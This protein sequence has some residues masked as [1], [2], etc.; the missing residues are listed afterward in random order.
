MP[1]SVS[2][3]FIFSKIDIE[4]ILPNELIKEI[5][6]SAKKDDIDKDE[7]KKIIKKVLADNPQVAIDYKAGKENILQF[8][9]GQVMYIIKKKIDTNILKELILEELK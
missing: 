5:S 9:I 8:A 7:L 6:F 4:K 3:D 2:R 1:R